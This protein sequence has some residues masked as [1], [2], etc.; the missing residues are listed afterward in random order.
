MKGLLKKFLLYEI[1]HINW[2][3]YSPLIICVETASYSRNGTETKYEEIISYLESKGYLNYADTRINTIFIKK[4]RYV[5][6]N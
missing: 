2:D 4:D 1:G 3:K 6:H 5:E